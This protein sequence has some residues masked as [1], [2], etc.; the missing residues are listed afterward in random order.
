M[1]SNYFFCALFIKTIGRS[2]FWLYSAIDGP[3]YCLQIY[4]R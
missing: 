2:V 3:S 4:T 1:L